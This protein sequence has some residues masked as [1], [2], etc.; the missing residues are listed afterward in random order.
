MQNY[1]LTPLYFSVQWFHYRSAC[2]LSNIL[3]RSSTMFQDEDRDHRNLRGRGRWD[4]RRQRGMGRGGGDWRTNSMNF[5]SS[6]S[7][8]GPERN[9]H[10]HRGGYRG[11]YYARLNK[12]KQKNEEKKDHKKLRLKL[13]E[14]RQQ[15]IWKLLGETRDDPMSGPRD[16]EAFGCASSKYEHIADSAFKRQFLQN[17][18]DN[19]R[20]SLGPRDVVRTA[21]ER[22]PE[23][24]MT[25]QK[26]IQSYESN[27]K[28]I[29]MQFNRARLPAS[30][31]QE[32][33]LQL[34]RENQVIV[35][36]GETGCGK[37]TQ[38]TQYILDDAMH[39][40][41]GSLCRVVCTQ[42]RRISAI[43]V[44]QRVADERIEPLGKSVGYQIRLENRQPRNR[45]SILYCTTGI[46]IQWLQSDPYLEQISHLIVDE[47]H[48]RDILSDFVLTVVK[49]LLPHR[50]EMKLILM[51]A[52]LNAKSF[53]RYYN[54]CPILHI[55]GLTFPVETFYLEDVLQKTGFSF[56]EVKVRPGEVWKKH[57]SRGREGEKKKQEY[58]ELMGPFVRKLRSDGLYDEHVLQ[59]LTNPE[60]EEIN[61]ELIAA[62][63]QYIC[64]TQ[65]EGAILVFLPGWD[66]ISK[67]YNF[68]TDSSFYSPDRYHVLPLHSAMPTVN[69]K[70]IFLRPPRGTSITIDDV[71]F[72]VDCGKIKMTN[73]DVQNN[74]QTLKAEWPGVCFHL[75]T[76]RREMTLAQY[77]LPEMLRSRLEEVILQLKIL[78]L[79]IVRP[80]LSKVL[81][82]PDPLAVDKSIELLE[83]LNALDESENLT[84]LGFHLAKLPMDPQTGKMILMGAL[85]RCLDP[86][87]TVA[88]SLSHK[89][90]FILPLGRER[91][92]ENK[93]LELSMGLKSDHLVFV[94]A[95]RLWEQA[96]RTNSGRDFCWEHFLSSNTLVMLRNMKGQLAEYL[97]NLNFISTTNPKSPEFNINSHN[98][99]L[100]KAIVC[101]GLKVKTNKKTGRTHIRLITPQD[102]R[103]EI[104]PKSVNAKQSEFESP[105][106]LYHLK[107][108]SSAIYLHDTTM[109]YPLPLLFFGGRLKSMTDADGDNL[110]SM[111]ALA[112]TELITTEDKLN[113]MLP[114][115]CSDDDDDDY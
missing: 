83:T 23:L 41:D 46:L 75:F 88:A 103:V 89:D 42:P 57:T 53:S 27:K 28:Y 5:S 16:Q 60:S 19:R 7:R 79:G 81:D 77:Q 66:Q 92:A 105:Y 10:E 69:Q 31:K 70:E 91:Q 4:G 95:M 64:N 90:A 100:V 113:A 93:K 12:E 52:T 106:L 96:E 49:D 98:R 36:S 1:L 74:L 6:G 18:E 94:E 47:I 71:V 43:S 48:E 38:V 72:V 78:K 30:S 115:Q 112:I 35:I 24:D 54:D 82:P 80:F 33:I 8:S 21:I 9:E 65:P 107:L 25:L 76:R 50:P 26:E 37:T 101:S 86:I 109:V 51:S 104:H 61:L 55:P 84:P 17:L 108:R 73:Y 59:S 22:N 102:G 97:E 32:E 11:L 62:L 44:A 67:M 114:E 13:D 2:L 39:S 110:L 56:A 99:S 85:F 45:G 111:D 34:L 63:V 58:H 68:I 3:I 20:A 14:N 87:L 15:Q 40:G 29:D